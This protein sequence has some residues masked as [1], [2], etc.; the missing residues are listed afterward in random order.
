MSATSSRLRRQSSTPGLEPCNVTS[1]I[2][3]ES[4]A[5]FVGKRQFGYSRDLMVWSSW[6]SHVHH[7]D[8][9]LARFLRGECRC[10]TLP[11]FG[12]TDRT[13]TGGCQ[14]Y[15]FPAEPEHQIDPVPMRRRIGESH[16]RDS[17]A[18]AQT[19]RLFDVRDIIPADRRTK[20]SES[21]LDQA[22]VVEE[23]VFDSRHRIVALGVDVV[24]KVDAREIVKQPGIA[25]LPRNADSFDR[26]VSSNR[27]RSR[28]RSSS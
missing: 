6:R 13:S 1:S 21:R 17:I 23:G 20:G 3:F 9:Y 7:H 8:R 25:R 18:P 2:C 16:E 10:Q 26:T 11:Q 12:S 28:W 15:V 5:P 19:Y 4:D 22:L 14:R 27:C 24:R